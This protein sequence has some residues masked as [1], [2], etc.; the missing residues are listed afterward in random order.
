MPLMGYGA[1]WRNFSA[2][3]ERAKLACQNT[4]D[5]VTSLFGDATKK[6]TGGRPRE[7]FRLTRYAA[8]LVAMNGDPR[9][10]EVAAAQAYFA[11]QTRNAEL[12][13]QPM[14]GLTTVWAQQQM[15]S[16]RGIPKRQDARSAATFAAPRKW[17]V[18]SSAVAVPDE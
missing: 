7:D 9:K 14:A 17:L 11:V 3:V 12:A 6:S 10:P 16:L 4:G 1:D 2:A 8:Y 15:A 5:D 13:Q 18:T